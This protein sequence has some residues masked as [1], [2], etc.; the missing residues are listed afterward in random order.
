MK[1]V[2]KSLNICVTIPSNASSSLSAPYTF[3]EWILTLQCSVRS[4]VFILR[5]EL[6]LFK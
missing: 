2:Y 6:S 1:L 4:A 3:I 5:L